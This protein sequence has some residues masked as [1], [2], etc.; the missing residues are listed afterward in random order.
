[1]RFDNKYTFS[2]YRRWQWRT[3]VE[4]LQGKC[5]VCLVCTVEM[6][7]SSADA[8]V[9][10]NIHVTIRTSANIRRHLWLRICGV[11]ALTSGVN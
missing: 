9:R 1:M 10:P 8:E 11:F 4:W 2:V 6:G 5:S 7:R 3:F